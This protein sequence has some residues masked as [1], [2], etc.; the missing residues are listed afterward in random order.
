MAQ[1][2]TMDGVMASSKPK[3]A[4]RGLSRPRKRLLDP[5]RGDGAGGFWGAQT[6]PCLRWRWPCGVQSLIRRVPIDNSPVRDTMKQP[7]VMTL[8]TRPKGGG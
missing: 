8:Y 3:P 1:I 6:G 7:S 4:Q 2:I 5:G